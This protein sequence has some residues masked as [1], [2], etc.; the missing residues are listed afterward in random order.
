MTTVYELWDLASGNQISSF[1]SELDA[2][3]VARKL[4]DANGPEVLEALAL[5]VVRI[6]EGQE[7]ELSPFVDGDELR[8]RLERLPANLKR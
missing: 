3:M 8:A 5:G 2:L 7:P 1:E 4:I 6:R